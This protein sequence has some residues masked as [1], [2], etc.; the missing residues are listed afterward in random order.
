MIQSNK[1]LYQNINK[2]IAELK[3]AGQLEYAKQLEDALS[4]STIPSEVLGETRLALENLEN[5]NFVDNLN[6][7]LDIKLSLEY[8]NRIL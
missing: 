4:I 2:I 3:K 6:I 1:D 7:R 5:A 8:L